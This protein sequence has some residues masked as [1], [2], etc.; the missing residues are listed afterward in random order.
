M[1]ISS[2]SKLLSQ[3]NDIELGQTAGSSKHPYEITSIYRKC[4][5]DAKTR[6]FP[7]VQV[8]V[9]S[10]GIIQSQTSRITVRQ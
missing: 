6:R 2:N 3:N 1:T 5:Q 9:V 4:S 8:N 7:T 10:H